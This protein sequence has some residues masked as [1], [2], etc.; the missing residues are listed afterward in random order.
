MKTVVVDASIAIKWVLQEPDS[1]IALALLAEWIEVGTAI[2]APALLA[3]ELLIASIE[4]LSKEKY[5]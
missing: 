4:S 1:N 5:H 3:Y 2:L